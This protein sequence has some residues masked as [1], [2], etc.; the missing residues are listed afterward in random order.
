MRGLD[1]QKYQQFAKGAAI[2]TLATFIVKVL[3]AVYRVPYQNLAG[4]IAFYV[5]QQVYPLYGILLVFSTYGFPVIISKLVAEQAGEGK[6]RAHSQILCAS[7]IG[8]LCLFLSLFIFFIRYTYE[9]SLFLGDSELEPLIYVVSFF[10]LL[11]PF[12][13]V[14][15]GYFQGHNEMIPTATSQVLEQIIRVSIIVIATFLLVPLKVD[16]YTIGATALLGGVIGSIAG[17]MSLFFFFMKKGKMI[18]DWRDFFH[19]SSFRI[20]RIV[21]VQ[22]LTICVANLVLILMQ[23]LD[24]VTLYTLLV[25]SG[26]GTHMAKVIKGVYDRGLPL[27]QVGTIVATS[28]SL[29]FIPVI[30]MA[31]ARKEEKMIKDKIVLSLKINLFVGLAAS[32]GLMCVMKSTNVMLFEDANGTGTLAI[33]GYA[34]LFGSMAM[35]TATILQGIGRMWLPVLHVFVGA[36]IKV[37]GNILFV[38]LL[39]VAG[40]AVATILS[41]AFITALNYLAIVRH[42]GLRLFG[43]VELR[44]ALIISG[45]MAGVLIV[46][47]IIE[48]QL[49]GR[50][51]DS[52]TFATVIT[53][54]NVVIGGIVYIW[55]LIKSKAFSYKEVSDLTSNTWIRSLFK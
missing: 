34:I 53:V 1:R 39:G 31:Y 13:A 6:E 27:I 3:S 8:L 18:F 29:S 7:F 45:L 12:N 10:C 48:E 43:N 50:V 38:P 35:A 22:G 40:A 21:I 23:L 28:L 20:I 54:S 5:Y 14:L 24:S 37:I 30:S 32:V 17:G 19:A 11:I 49:F 25:E 44:K 26:A 36:I 47:S 41:L 55:L 42:T 4:D 2:L 33:L 51:G 46:C 16:V 15:R 9:L 52:R